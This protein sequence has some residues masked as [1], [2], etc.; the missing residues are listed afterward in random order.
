MCISL[1]RE[2]RRSQEEEEEDYQ[3]EF[4]KW[5]LWS[6]GGNKAAEVVLVEALMVFASVCWWR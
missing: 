1:A 3:K 5:K 2:I 6:K 4:G